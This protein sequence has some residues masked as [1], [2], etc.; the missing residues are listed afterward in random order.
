MLQ[1]QG[2]VP[3][4]DDGMLGNTGRYASHDLCCAGAIFYRAARL[5]G[6]GWGMAHEEVATTEGGGSRRRRQPKAAAA[7]DRGGIPANLSPTAGTPQVAPAHNRAEPHDATIGASR[8]HATAA[9]CQEGGGTGRTSCPRC[10]LRR[11]RA[12]RSPTRQ[13]DALE[14]LDVALIREQAQLLCSPGVLSSPAG[15]AVELE[16]AFGNEAHCAVR[17]LL[18]RMPLLDVGWL[19]RVAAWLRRLEQVRR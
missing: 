14:W 6:Y 17:G 4:P 19:G 11:S 1:A 3:P 8:Q 5:C 12:L 13:V 2:M 10:C 16:L 9:A 15:D 18:D 7:E